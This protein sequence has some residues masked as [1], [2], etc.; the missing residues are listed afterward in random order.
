MLYQ[1]RGIRDSS[2]TNFV[3]RGSEGAI[4]LSCCVG[5]PRVESPAGNG[6]LA[7]GEVRPQDV[8]QRRGALVL[9]ASRVAVPGRPM[10]AMVALRARLVVA[11]F[12]RSGRFRVMRRLRVMGRLRVVGRLRVMGRLGVMG[13]LV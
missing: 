7:R 12:R 6:S 5:W 1:A 11:V 8:V 10:V 13:R 3:C 2:S 4:G 9:A